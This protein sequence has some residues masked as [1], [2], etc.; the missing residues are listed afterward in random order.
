MMEK[1]PKSFEKILLIGV[2]SSFFDVSYCISPNNPSLSVIETVL[3][4]RESIRESIVQSL[5][6]ILYG[7]RI[8]AEYT[9]LNMI[10]KV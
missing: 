5:T 9:L 4:E 7:D 2:W 3:A 10:S 8:A 1:Y 6:K